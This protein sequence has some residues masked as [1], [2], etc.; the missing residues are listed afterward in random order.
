VQ[1]KHLV[2]VGNAA[3]E[4]GLNFAEREIH[5]YGQMAGDE[6]TGGAHVDYPRTIF[7]VLARVLYRDES[8]APVK[9]KGHDDYGGNKDVC[10][11]HGR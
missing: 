8:G 9:K 7:Q 1:Q 3:G 2:L 6:F 11:I 5:C 10:P 4:A